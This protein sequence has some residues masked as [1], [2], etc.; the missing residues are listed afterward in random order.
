M[1]SNSESLLLRFLFKATYNLHLFLL[2]MKTQ[3]HTQPKP[4]ADKVAADTKSES[5]DF[6]LWAVH[7]RQQMLDSLNRRGLR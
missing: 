4:Q 3:T 2:D 1:I 7:V 6:D 5:F